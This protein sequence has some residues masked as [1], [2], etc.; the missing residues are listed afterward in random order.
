MRLNAVLAP[1]TWLLSVAVEDNSGNGVSELLTAAQIAEQP[2]GQQAGRCCR[3]RWLLSAV[4]CF[5]SG[6]A[7]A[8][9]CKKQSKMTEQERGWILYLF[10]LT[11]PRASYRPPESCFVIIFRLV[12][13]CIVPPP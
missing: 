2:Q 4:M 8:A 5:A 13:A 1:V 10:V 7:A 11:C 12:I 6:A 9:S 3:W